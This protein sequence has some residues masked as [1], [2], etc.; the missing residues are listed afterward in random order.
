MNHQ[1]D[2]YISQ[3]DFYQKSFLTILIYLNDSF[4]GGETKIN[5][6]DYKVRPVTGSVLIFNHDINHE[7]CPITS[8]MKYVIRTDMM[9]TNAN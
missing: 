2:F 8:G 9:Y 1:D 7:G 3:G 4:E 5:D 6:I